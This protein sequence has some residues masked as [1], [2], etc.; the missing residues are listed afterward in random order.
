MS[1]EEI[2]SAIQTSTI[3]SEDEVDSLV[4]QISTVAGDLDLEL[5]QKEELIAQ[6]L[7]LIERQPEPEFTSWSL[8]HFIEWL[9]EDGSTSYNDQLLQ[10]IKQSPK[11]LTLLLANRVL[12]SLT[13]ESPHQVKFLDALQEVASNPTFDDFVRSEANELHQYQVGKG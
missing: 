2:L 7:R 12:N 6:L 9:D 1:Y 13:E 3:T 5:W 11:Y 8:I 4:D 10:S